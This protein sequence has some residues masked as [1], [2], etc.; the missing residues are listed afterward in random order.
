MINF[1]RTKKILLIKTFF[2]FFLIVFLIP[3]NS[4]YAIDAIPTSNIS[5]EK[6]VNNIYT[7]SAVS[8][9]TELNQMAKR[10]QDE[11]QQI[12]DWAVTN[13]E[14]DEV[15]A[16]AL[17]NSSLS[18][19]LNYLKS[20]QK[21]TD[22]GLIENASAYAAWVASNGPG[23]IDQYIGSRLNSVS[24]DLTKARLRDLYQAEADWYNKNSELNAQVGNDVKSENLKKFGSAVQ[25]T[26]DDQSSAGSV[27]CWVGPDKGFFS[28]DGCMAVGAYNLLKFVVWIFGLVAMV[29]NE[30]ILYTLNMTELLSKI[31]IIDVGWTAVRDVINLIFIF[32]VLYVALNTIVGNADY[33]IKKMLSKIIIAAIFINFSLFF[34]QAMIDVSNIFALTFYTK[35]T[36]LQG[37]NITNVNSGIS[38]AIS[39]AIGLEWIFKNT[40]GAGD[41]N[42]VGLNATAIFT[43]AIGSTIFVMITLFVL[44]AGTLALI[45]RA[46]TLIFL[47]ILSPIAFIGGVVPQL[48]GVSGDWWKRLTQNLIFAP[49]Y[50]AFIYLVIYMTSKNNTAYNLKDIFVDSP[51]GWNKAVETIINMIVINAL[52]LGALMIAKSTGDSG[53]KSAMSWADSGLKKVRGAAGGAARWTVGGIYRNSIGYKAAQIAS[54]PEFQAKYSKS[55]LG[56]GLISG[57][58]YLGDGFNKKTKETAESKTKFIDSLSKEKSIGTGKFINAID[59]NGNPYEKE[60]MTSAQDIAR[61]HLG[62]QTKSMFTSTRLAAANA[63]VES[64]K[65]KISDANDDLADISRKVKSVI[66]SVDKADQKRI[67]KGIRP[68]LKDAVK[69]GLS[70]DEIK[71]SVKKH[72]IKPSLPDQDEAAFAEIYM[73]EY[74]K[75][76]EL[77]KLKDKKLMKEYKDLAGRGGFSPK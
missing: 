29:F 58:R 32:L 67:T 38:A 46:I 13:E 72:Y 45:A 15:Q 4:T 10:V 71:D 11:A 62:G 26:A 28:L 60:I 49:V 9:K 44:F 56:R 66:G 5:V 7:S 36:Q 20:A 76:E 33:G 75:N 68:H 39:H 31:T 52:M 53:T 74:L 12:H 23:L 22:V 16:T 21:N 40:Q 19:G 59:E 50:M 17:K 48:K 2:V 27:L 54:N 47:M 43:F 63:K 14:A 77:N 1:L 73:D 24:D 35:I 18:A 34:T 3:F 8:G 41:I 6:Q 37:A 61:A 42:G 57:T 70:D 55:M 51:D 64:N 65:S 69:A 30:V 25:K